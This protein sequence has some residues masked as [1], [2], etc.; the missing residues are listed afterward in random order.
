M[1]LLD[2]KGKLF[3]IINI[4]DLCVILI[5]VIIAAG[6][7]YKFKVMD[8]TSNTAAMQPVTYTVKVEKI[9]SYVLDNVLEGDILYD[10]TSGNDI[11]KITKVESE[12]ATEF[13]SMSDGTVVKGNVENRINVIFTVE[14]DAVQNS[15]GCFV[16][17]TYERL[18]GSQRKF[19]TKYFECD[20]Y[21]NS[22]EE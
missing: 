8:K 6:T 7:F 20:G 4:I 13:I 5:V 17:R 10:K 1:K 11:G 3:G 2:R 9:R 14:A 22:I 21:I 16:N 15:S 19:M 12:P 18:V